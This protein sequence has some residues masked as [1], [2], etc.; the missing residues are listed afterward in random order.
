MIEQAGNAKPK[1]N[2]NTNSE[3]KRRGRKPKPGNLSTKEYFGNTQEEAIKKY[4]KEDLTKQQKNELFRDIIDPAL[5]ALVKGVLK[6]PKFQKIIGITSEQLEED[7]YYHVVFQITKF[8][9]DKIGKTGDP[10]KAFSYLGTVVK[11]Y[12]LGVKIQNDGQIANHGGILNV[13]DLGDYL[14]D[15]G[16][17][18]IDFEEFKGDII[19]QLEKS[20]DGK[21]LNKNDLVVG[22][23]LK[24]MLINWHRLEFQ[25]K[26]EFVRLLC[27][28]T[29]LNPPVV[30]RSLKKY[31]NLVY[32][33]LAYPVGKPR[34]I[35]KIKK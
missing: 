3:P 2:D 8:N 18:P 35:K 7:A 23:T 32:D 17:N 21:R 25:S 24:Y 13:D 31:K 28:Y 14:T 12:V 33:L 26:N 9:P 30:A 22:N 34:K 15:T 11:N 5:K 27:H 20:I 1:P 4:I 19:T 16:K 29:Q 10:V 6:M